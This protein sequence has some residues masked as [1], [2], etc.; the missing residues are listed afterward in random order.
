[1]GCRVAPGVVQGRS[2]VDPPSDGQKI[3][4]I[5]WKKKENQSYLPKKCIHTVPNHAACLAHLAGV[6]TRAAFHW[7]P[8]YAR[9]VR[10][11]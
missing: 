2:F 10:V 8:L 3:G 7:S 11:M 6:C 1:M 9:D 4:D 5:D